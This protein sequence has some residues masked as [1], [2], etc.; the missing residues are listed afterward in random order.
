MAVNLLVS[1]GAE[2]LAYLCT[3]TVGQPLA[4][5]RRVLE[6]NGFKVRQVTSV[7]T[8]PTASSWRNHPCSKIGSGAV[9]S[10]QVT[11]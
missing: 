2:P 3:R 11:Q 4:S 6:K 7:A 5:A 8:V 9:I 10:F 1:G